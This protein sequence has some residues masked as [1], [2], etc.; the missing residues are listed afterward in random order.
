ME[1]TI[2]LRDVKFYWRSEIMLE[3]MLQKILIF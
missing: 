3:I 2:L 1:R